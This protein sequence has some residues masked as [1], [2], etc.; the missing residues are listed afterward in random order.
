MGNQ[1]LSLSLSLS[2]DQIWPNQIARLF[3]DIVVI[4][5]IILTTPQTKYYIHTYNSSR[6][7]TPLLWRKKYSRLKSLI[8]MLAAALEKSKRGLPRYRP[9]YR[10]TMGKISRPLTSLFLIKIIIIHDPSHVIT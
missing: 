5:I 10:Q 9:L 4:T 7:L 6:Q 1:H 3:V 2:S 8:P